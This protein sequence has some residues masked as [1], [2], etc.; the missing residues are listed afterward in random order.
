MQEM[1]SHRRRFLLQLLAGGALGLTPVA[2]AALLQGKLFNACGAALPQHLATHPLV[3]SAW[4]GIAA[5][6]FWDCHAHIAGTGDSGS[7]IYTSPNMSEAWHPVEFAQHEFY[8]N[9]ACAKQGDIDRSYVTRVLHLL[10]ELRPGCKLLLLAFDQAHDATG[11]P[12]PEHTAFHVPDSYALALVRAHP[13]QFEW[14]CSIHP[15]RPDAVDALEEAVRNNA[16]AVKWLPSAMGIDPASQKCDPFYAALARLDIP[17]ICHG[18]EERAVNGA[19]LP[20]D[21]NPLLLRRALEKGVR[22]VVAHCA[23]VGD[24]VDLDRG[25]HGPRVASFELFARLMDND[26]YRQHLFGDISAI[27]LRNR[28]PAT[29][30]ALLEHRDWHA[31]L[32]NGSDYPLPGVLPLTSPRLW[33]KSGLLDN[34]AVPVL[35]EIQNYN[36]LLFDFV[37]KRQLRAGSVS[38]PAD[39]FHTR[40]F[41]LRANAG[42]AASPAITDRGH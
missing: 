9:A 4:K 22:V 29:L 7:G 33:A 15:Y 35:N 26:A 38:F 20:G 30:R 32:L 18:G 31:R 16:R 2:R 8:L 6:R 23:S 14:A 28:S 12:L 39:V 19:G 36:P 41:F 21:N 37:L 24:N 3:I 25:A 34:A 1:N 42:Q 27:V 40:D 17:L 13:Q 5:E 10:D 11:K